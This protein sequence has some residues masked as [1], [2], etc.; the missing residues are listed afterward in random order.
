[1]PGSEGS[2]PV[3]WV[4]LTKS[5][6]KTGSLAG[7]PLR[8]GSAATVELTVTDADTAISIRSG[9]VPVLATPRLVALF[10]EAAMLAVAGQLGDN[11]TTV[12]MRV[13][14]DH[15]AP[16]PVGGVISAEATLD[17]VEGRRLIFNVAAHDAKGLIGAGKITRVVVDVDRFL[18]K[19]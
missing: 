5:E 12:G 8:P 4:T 3:P 1:M 15:L 2:Q 19:L 7:M 9:E 6:A 11:E 13:Q 10:E 14:V 18:D 16:T 17:R